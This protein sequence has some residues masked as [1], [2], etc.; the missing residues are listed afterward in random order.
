MA[1]YIAT[2]EIAD[3]CVGEVLNAIKQSNLEDDTI[4][5]FTTDHGLPMPRMKCNLFDTGTGVSFIMKIPKGKRNGEVTDY[6]I[7]HT[8]V[9]P[10]LC[11]LLNIEKPDWL[12]GKSFINVLNEEPGDWDNEIFSEVN[13]HATYEPM[14]SIR[15]KRYKLIKKFD[16]YKKVMPSNID[17]SPSKSL[18]LENGYME[19][20]VY[21]EMLFDLY[22]DPVER[23]NEINN[24]RY[25]AVYKSLS[26]KLKDN[27]IRT[28]DPLLEGQIP[29]P[30]GAITLPQSALSPNE[31]L[32]IMTLKL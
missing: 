21:D 8:D 6:L 9:F 10:T 12:E 30:K 11:D 13:F 20:E 27:M 7:S 32:E 19:T 29:L 23:V 31:L 5:I 25:E 26:Q 1:E 18:I 2:A 4:V 28:K 24:P 22:L 15:T 17:D 14:R 3:N 16:D